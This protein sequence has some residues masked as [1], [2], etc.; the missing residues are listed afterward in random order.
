LNSSILGRFPNFGAPSNPAASIKLVFCRGLWVPGTTIRSQPLR[1]VT[2]R[3]TGVQEAW[4]LRSRSMARDGA[5]PSG[6][7]ASWIDVSRGIERPQV[8][9]GPT[10]PKPRDRGWRGSA[11]SR[12][13]WTASL[14]VFHVERHSS[15]SPSEPL[16]VVPGGVSR[17][18]AR[19]L[20]FRPP[21]QTKRLRSTSAWYGRPQD[22]R[23]TGAT[24]RLPSFVQDCLPAYTPEVVPPPG[25]FFR[26]ERSPGQP[27]DRH[28]WVPYSPR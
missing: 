5:L 12:G 15:P 28:Q 27:Q 14:R 2:S 13:E 19:S 22:L 9:P 10:R 18:T 3:C 8:I 16:P 1:R 4:P 25:P 11:F 23:D 21:T 26:P 24:G 17:G 7:D 6:P 20:A